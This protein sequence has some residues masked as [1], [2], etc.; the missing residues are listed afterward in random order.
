MR[1]QRRGTDFTILAHDHHHISLLCILKRRRKFSRRRYMCMLIEIKYDITRI[2]ECVVCDVGA[3]VKV[4]SICIKQFF[5]LCHT[6]FTEPWTSFETFRRS[7]VWRT[8]DGD[9]SFRLNFLRQTSKQITLT[10]V[11][12]TSFLGWPHFIEKTNKIAPISL[13]HYNIEITEYWTT[14]KK[15]FKGQLVNMNLF[16]S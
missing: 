6:I 14:R 16:L 2:I 8:P 9:P 10:T 7:R 1:F 5:R 3:R 12:S 15:I 13:A 4:R 11:I